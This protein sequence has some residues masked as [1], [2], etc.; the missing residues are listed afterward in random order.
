MQAKRIEWTASASRELD[1][2][3]DYILEE[4]LSEKIAKNLINSIFQRTQQI[5]LM[6][7][8]GQ[9]EPNLSK[10]SVRY[11]VEGNYKILYKYQNEIIIITDIFHTK[12][13]PAKMTNN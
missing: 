2:I 10:F 7:L 5:E 12:R 13:N 1:K 3:Y 9:I 8:S 6:P 11:V 4:S